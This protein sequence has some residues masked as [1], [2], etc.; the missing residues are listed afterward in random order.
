MSLDS[1]ELIVSGVATPGSSLPH[2][3]VSI[4]LVRGPLDGDEYV[5][6]GRLCLHMDSAPLLAVPFKLRLAAL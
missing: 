5:R 6:V 2:G 4:R 3:A 1:V